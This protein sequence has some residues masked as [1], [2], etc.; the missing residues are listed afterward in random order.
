MATFI[1]SQL[2]V[3]CHIFLHT[4][5]KSCRRRANL[6]LASFDYTIPFINR[7]ARC[8]EKTTCSRGG[9]KIITQPILKK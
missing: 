8:R 3:K 1:P 9:E 5:Y 6:I 2:L 4:L 7:L